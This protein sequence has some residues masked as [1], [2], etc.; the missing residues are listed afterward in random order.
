MKIYL[1]GSGAIGSLFAAYLAKSGMDLTLVARNLKVV[2][3]IRRDGLR[4]TGVRGD[5]SVNVPI[6]TEVRDDPRA[7][8]ALICVKAYDTA[9]A[10]LQHDVLL[11]GAKTIVSLQ[12]GIGNVEEL[13][14]RFGEDKILAGSTTMGAFV[15]GPGS[16]HHAG[17]GETIIGEPRG[18]ISADTQRVADAFCAAGLPTAASENINKPL[19]TKL[20]VNVGINAMC[21]LLRVRNGVLA[22]YDS[23]KSI[24]RA[25]V[26]EAQKVGAQM[27]VDLDLDEMQNL[28]VEISRKTANNRSS[29]LTDI[30]G[31]RRTEIDYI[32]GAVVRMGRENKIATPVNKVLANLVIALHETQSRR[33]EN[34]D[35]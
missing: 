14:G 8:L 2:E 23:T 11:Q 22:E 34:M 19:W 27:G 31:D 30:L 20:C 17:E 13:A 5:L 7:D 12:N 21:A 35:A 18:G 28:T 16:I 4:V 6:L 3:Q 15:T 24:M 9:A 32:N 25:A 29:M 1:I 33:I 26:A 10:A